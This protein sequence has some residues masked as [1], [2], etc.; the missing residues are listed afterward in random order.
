LGI[1]SQ[2]PLAVV[3]A[4]TESYSAGCSAPSL[5]A[6]YLPAQPQAF[7][8]DLR[9]A[10]RDHDR[11]FVATL[12]AE[13]ASFC[14]RLLAYTPDHDERCLDRPAGDGLNFMRITDACI[15][16]KDARTA[17]EGLHLLLV[18]AAER[19]GLKFPGACRAMTP[20]PASP[21]TLNN[22][23]NALMAQAQG[24]RDLA[25][26]RAS[27]LQAAHGSVKVRLRNRGFVLGIHQAGLC[28]AHLIQQHPID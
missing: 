26:R 27:E 13:T 16:D 15:A 14:P 7:V 20:P 5:L 8:A 2:R 10:G 25:E 11:D 24:L 3:A 23:M 12:A 6:A 22:L 19:A 1:V 17:D 21:G 9:G 28:L 18:L 4:D